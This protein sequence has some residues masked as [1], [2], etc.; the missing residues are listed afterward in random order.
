MSLTPAAKIIV[1]CDYMNREDFTAFVAQT[2]EDVIQLAEKK[3]GKH[4]GR[5]FA[6]QWLG[7]SH[8]VVA[9]N[10]AEYIA[11]RVYL[12]E[13]R[14]FPCVDIGVGDLLP[15][16]T[17]L[18]VGSVAGYKPG[19]LQKNWTG[20]LGPFIHIIGQPFLNKMAG[21]ES[22]WSPDKPFPYITPEVTGT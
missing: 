22:L 5:K 16:G 8:P 15:D 9:E 17:P 7:G 2:L 13:E 18:I 3:C 1:A 14:I 4:L 10:V 6:F 12:D 20:R 11:E 21:K 19:P